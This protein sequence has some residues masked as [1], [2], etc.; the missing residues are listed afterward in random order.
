MIKLKSITS[1]SA[2]I[3]PVVPTLD[4]VIGTDCL[5][6]HAPNGR[7]EGSTFNPSG[8]DVVDKFADGWENIKI[9]IYNN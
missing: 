6:E 7:R 5:A 2:M 3:H 4:V 1:L 8:P 9:V